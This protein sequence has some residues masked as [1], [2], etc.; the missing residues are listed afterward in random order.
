MEPKLNSEIRVLPGNW[1]E[2]TLRI[3][4]EGDSLQRT[5]ITRNI[6]RTK[7]YIIFVNTWYE[8]SDKI[9]KYAVTSPKYKFHF[10]CLKNIFSELN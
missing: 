3:A 10:M 5:A 7:F 1:R 2:M 8:D 6:R 4:L 9:I